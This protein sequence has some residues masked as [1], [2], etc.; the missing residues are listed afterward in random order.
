MFYHTHL[1]LF[2]FKH[3]VTSFTTLKHCLNK[4][5]SFQLG[6]F[7]LSHRFTDS[8]ITNRIPI[9]RLILSLDDWFFYLL[10]PSLLF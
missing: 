2:F 1:Q 6:E 3:D 7:L 8:F 5:I 9:N 4:G 10:M